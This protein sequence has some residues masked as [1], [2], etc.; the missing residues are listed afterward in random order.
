MKLVVLEIFAYDL[1]VE[2]SLEFDFVDS[3]LSDVFGM[4]KL[5]T[6]VKD[7]FLFDWGSFFLVFFSFFFLIGVVFV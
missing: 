2:R 4:F 7:L 5:D 6:D 1:G 3:D